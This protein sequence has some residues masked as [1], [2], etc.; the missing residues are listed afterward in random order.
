MKNIYFK[1]LT[2]IALMMAAGWGYL[3]YRSK[4]N[5]NNEDFKLD[6]IICGV[7]AVGFLILL[8]LGFKKRS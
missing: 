1:I 5:G 8:F 4:T 2:I 6:L 3:A 7:S